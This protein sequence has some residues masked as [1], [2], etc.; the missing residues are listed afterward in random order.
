MDELH[1]PRA[2]ERMSPLA[3]IRA[4][5]QRKR[6]PGPDRLPRLPDDRPGRRGPFRERPDAASRVAVACTA[7][8]CPAAGCWCTPFTALLPDGNRRGSRSLR[9]PC[10]KCP[11]GCLRPQRFTGS[12]SN[13]ST[14][15]SDLRSRFGWPG[16][17]VWGASGRRGSG[18][19]SAAIG[20][21]ERSG[22]AC[23]HPNRPRPIRS[24][25][26]PPPRAFLSPCRPPSGTGGT[27]SGVFV[28]ARV[29]LRFGLVRGTVEPA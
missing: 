4:R 24:P 11:A 6:V 17:L 22:S 5:R 10:R 9:P 16:W 28:R 2:C 8:A 1:R 20:R 15:E 18:C 12:R 26:P 23:N 27:G 25:S 3:S 7:T 21:R 29:M 14:A 13:H 19:R